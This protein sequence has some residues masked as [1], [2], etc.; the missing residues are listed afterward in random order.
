MKEKIKIRKI[1]YILIFGLVLAPMTGLRIMKVGPAEILCLIWCLV[2]FSEYLKIKK[3]DFVLSFWLVFLSCICL[4]TAFG[5]IFYPH[6]SQPLQI[7][8]YIY[9]ML[10]SIGV[11]AGL[12]K[13]TL[14]YIE[15]MLEEICLY[16]TLWYFFLFLYSFLVAPSFFGAPLWYSEQRFSGGGTNPHQLAVLMGANVFI[17]YRFLRIKREINQKLKYLLFIIIGVIIALETL[18]STLIMSLAI[19][20]ILAIVLEI[21]QREKTQKKKILTTLLII[22]FSGIIFLL[23]YPY[24]WGRGLNW[25][26]SD[27]N[28]LGRLEI[29]SSFTETLKKNPIVGLG[30]GNHAFNGM[31]EYHNTYLE[32]IAM[33]GFIGFIIFIL[34][35]KRI[36]QIMR[37]DYTLKLIIIP[38]Y[39]YGLAG[40]SMRR[41]AFWVL[42]MFVLVVA[43][44]IREEHNLI[45]I[46]E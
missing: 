10:I 41:L 18:S 30:P 4:G 11:Y 23:F 26:S 31:I 35:S 28:G 14:P 6:E 36:F 5:Y 12:S 21:I 45:Y 29:F 7:F 16:V 15:K 13:N 46:G 22:I 40:F 43:K 27:P 1:D 17:C 37:V 25:I 3:N 19:T 34:F 20:I 39:L 42:L 2:N 9:L 38:L 33:S 32:I 8:T 24:I 44:K